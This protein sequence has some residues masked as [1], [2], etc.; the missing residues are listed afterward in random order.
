VAQSRGL[1]GTIKGSSLPSRA[2]AP[3]IP[4]TSP[5]W[6]EATAVLWLKTVMP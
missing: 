1:W 4:V 5:A 2:S 3:N 6:G